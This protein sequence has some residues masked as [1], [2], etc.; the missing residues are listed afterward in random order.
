MPWSLKSTE[1]GLGQSCCSEQAQ[2]ELATLYPGGCPKS[3]RGTKP[4][5][6]RRL[7]AAPSWSPVQEGRGPR[8]TTPGA[9]SPQ[10]RHRL[11]WVPEPGPSRPVVETSARRP[12]EKH[13]VKRQPNR[14]DG[15]RQQEHL[16]S[17]G[18]GT[19]ALGPADMTRG[20]QA[21]RVNSLHHPQDR[22]QARDPRASESALHS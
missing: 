21:C 10:P 2:S 1:A 5:T 13:L 19:G 17:C 22:R 11:S 6:W 12:K 14:A 16:S 4:R 3:R 15:S 7:P 18:E 8:P 20:R 9:L